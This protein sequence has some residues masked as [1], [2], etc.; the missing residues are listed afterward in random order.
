MRDLNSEGKGPDSV[1]GSV[2]VTFICGSRNLMPPTRLKNR[3]KQKNQS[4]VVQQI[5]D[6]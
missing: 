1:L 4:F 2:E 5:N 6:E 3:R